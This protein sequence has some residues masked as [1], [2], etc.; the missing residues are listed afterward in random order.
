MRITLATRT[1][2]AAMQSGE[3][4]EKM[5]TRL[6]GALSLLRHDRWQLAARCGE[7]L[8]VLAGG[9]AHELA[10]PTAVRPG[11]PA[12]LSSL[13][14]RALAE[15]RTVVVSTLVVVPGPQEGEDWETDWATLLYA[16]VGFPRCRP[17]GLLALGCRDAVWY[18]DIDVD[19]VSAV[20]QNLA[21]F[22]ADAV[23]P[24]RRLSRSE[25]LVAYLLADG[26]SGEEVAR[27]MG[28]KRD[29]ASALIGRLLRKLRLRSPNEVSSV[30][31]RALLP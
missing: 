15:R 6:E 3:R 25:R 28:V 26:C 4:S 17:N 21:D 5:L 29:D 13:G 14:R 16:P 11:Q 1:S 12:S 20:A 22:V 2:L 27:A 9:P 8:V 24:L 23:E 18:E 10:L 30:I 31:D 19:F 7:D